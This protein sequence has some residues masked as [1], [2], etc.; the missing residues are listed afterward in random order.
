MQNWICEDNNQVTQINAM[1]TDFIFINEIF[2][3]EKTI[4]I[5]TRNP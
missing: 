3:S 4:I 5:S 2:S 1:K